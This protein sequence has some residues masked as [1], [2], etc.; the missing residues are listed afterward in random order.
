MGGFWI[1]QRSAG[2]HPP[3]GI[4][5]CPPPCCAATCRRR[6]SGLESL[7]GFRGGASTGVGKGRRR[8]ARAGRSIHVE[9]DMEGMQAQAA[10]R[11]TP[12]ATRRSVRRSARPLT[13]RRPSARPFA[14][15]RPRPTSPS[16][17][18]ISRFPMQLS[19]NGFVRRLCFRVATALPSVPIRHPGP[20]HPFDASKRALMPRASSVHRRHP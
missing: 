13:R 15:L 10:S 16:A 6:F 4:D 19:P 1:P 5:G 11:E 18:S 20:F 9:D 8:R 3:G 2:E 7:R 14:A 12:P 17:S